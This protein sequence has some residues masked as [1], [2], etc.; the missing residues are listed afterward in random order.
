MNL[1]EYIEENYYEVLS[2][3]ESI[4]GK[5]EID[6][7]DVVAEMYL[8]LHKR[9]SKIKAIP[10]EKQMKFYVLRWL[11]SRTY[12][13]GGNAVNMYKI[14]ESSIEDFMPVDMFVYSM[15]KDEVTE[16]LSRAG[17]GELEIEKITSCIEVSKTMP[18]YYKRL[19]V[20]YYIDGM[21]MLEIGNSCGL[22]K[23]AIFTQLKKVQ[24]HLKTHLKLNKEK[25]LL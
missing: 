14:P 10:N 21:T 22:P 16:D 2:W 4:Y 8:D 5:T 18:L 7:R 25:M 17:F 13:S 15:E 9:Q 19:F 11:K 24:T 23:S 1:N 12:W 20:L 6:P 3:A